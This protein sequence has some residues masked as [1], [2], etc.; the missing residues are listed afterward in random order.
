M[1]WEWVNPGYNGYQEHIRKQ[2]FRTGFCDWILHQT[3]G[4]Q[5]PIAVGKWGSDNAWHIASQ[6]L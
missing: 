6:L 5:D 4:N 3:A 1:W 2:N